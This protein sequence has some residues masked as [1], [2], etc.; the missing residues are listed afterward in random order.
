MPAE[1]AAALASATIL[2]A[3]LDASP[4]TVTVGFQAGG[5]A[6]DLDGHRAVECSLAHNLT[7]ELDGCARLD[8]DGRRGQLDRGGRHDDERHRGE[9]KS[10]VGSG[11][12][13]LGLQ[14]DGRRP[15]GRGDGRLDR[16]LPVGGL[17]G[18]RRARRQSG[19]AARR[20][21]KSR[22]PRRPPSCG[23]RLTGQV[24]LKP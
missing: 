23:P 9:A 17:V 7:L 10:L 5:Q 21:A 15:Q 12:F 22:V 8:L 1:A 18:D 2:T 6:V 4:A 19:P 11:E 14:A 24:A 13:T 3:K 20:V 16:D